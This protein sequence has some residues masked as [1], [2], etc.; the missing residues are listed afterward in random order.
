MGSN[1]TASASPTQNLRH[2][3]LIVLPKM[4]LRSATRSHQLM[5]AAHFAVHFAAHDGAKV[6]PD[7]NTRYIGQ[8]PGTAGNTREQAILHRKNRVLRC[9]SVA[10]KRSNFA[11]YEAGRFR[12][13]VVSGP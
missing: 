8:K 7:K 4:A 9:V 13:N 3:P 1:P 6:S 11:L 2:D 12:S 5:L 10:L